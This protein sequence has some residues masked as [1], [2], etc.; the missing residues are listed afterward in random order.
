MLD[1][2]QWLLRDCGLIIQIDRQINIDKEDKERIVRSCWLERV[3]FK[4]YEGL[5]KIQA[6]KFTTLNTYIHAR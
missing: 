6:F 1:F 4:D 5:F 3:V 2:S